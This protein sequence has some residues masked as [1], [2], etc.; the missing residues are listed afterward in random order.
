MSPAEFE[1][2]DRRRAE[3]LRRSL[4]P[5]PTL[6]SPFP[7]AQTVTILI[8]HL[9]EAEEKVRAM[10]MKA[11]DAVTNVRLYEDLRDQAIAALLEAAQVKP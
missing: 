1:E 3:Y 2:R 5:A 7:P 11:A 10:R 8:Q 4:Y 6:L 9:A